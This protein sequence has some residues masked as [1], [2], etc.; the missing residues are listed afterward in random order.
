MS[1]KL[2]NID[3]ATI[4]KITRQHGDAKPYEVIQVLDEEGD[5][6]YLFPPI[7]SVAEVK[8]ILREINYAYDKGYDYGSASRARTICDAL[9]FKRE[10]LED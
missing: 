7:L 2:I 5:E 3:T 10:M 6:K 9:G 8:S 4:H 1:R